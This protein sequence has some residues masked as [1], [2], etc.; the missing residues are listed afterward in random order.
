MARETKPEK[1]RVPKQR[2]SIDKKNR[3][4]EAAMALFAKNGIHKTNSKEIAAEAGVAI[5]SFYS[6][7]PDK[8]KLLADVLDTYLKDHFDR[9]WKDG[10]ALEGMSFRE[11]IRRLI[12]NLLEAYNESPDFHRETHVLRYSDPE[13]KALYD[14]ETEKELRRISETLEHLREFLAVTDVEAAAVVI[15]SAAENLAH[16]IKFMGTLDEKRLTAEFTDMITRYLSKG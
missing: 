5:G 8:K 13:V 15:H 12:E 9:I 10:A 1:T 14:R 2:R 3:I 16:K 4:M 7:F 11:I 6:Y